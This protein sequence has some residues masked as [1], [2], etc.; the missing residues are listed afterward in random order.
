MEGPI[1]GVP[2]IFLLDT[3]RSM[4]GEGFAQ[5]KEAFLS[6]IQG[7]ANQSNVDH[8]VAVI[9]FGKETKILQL[10]SNDFKS[11][12]HLLDDIVCEGPSQLRK[13]MELAIEVL[14]TV[15]NQSSIGPFCI[16]EK[17]VIISRGRVADK[18][19]VMYMED[20]RHEKLKIVHLAGQIGTRHPIVCIPVGT[21]PDMCFLGSLACSS[22]TG[23][24]LS[25]EG[26]VQFT[27]YSSNMGIASEVIGNIPTT[28]YSVDDVKAAVQALEGSR[29]ITE[30]DVD[31]IYEILTH[32]H[33]YQINSYSRDTIETDLHSEGNPKLP[34]IGT[35]VRR[36]PNWPYNGQDSNTC[37][38]VV[39]HNHRDLNLSIEW[40]TSMIFPYHF[41]T[42]GDLG[43]S[44]VVV[45][46]EPRILLQREKIAVGCLV[47]RGPDWKWFDQDG[48]EDNVGSVYRVKD[49]KTVHVRWP[50]GNKS[51]YRFG[52][53]GKY[54]VSI[55]DPFDE[56]IRR[57]IEEQQK[58]WHK[59]INDSKKVVSNDGI[60]ISFS[61]EGR[62]ST[63]TI[64][65]GIGRGMVETGDSVIKA[66]ENVLEMNDS[67]DEARRESRAIEYKDEASGGG[68]DTDLNNEDNNSLWQW[69]NE[70][71]NW[72]YYPKSENDKIQKAHE[73]NSRGTILVRVNGDLY[74]VVLSKMIQ[75]NISSRESQEIRRLS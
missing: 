34:P 25:P 41:D 4:R 36:A 43:R 32:R 52:Y 63:L 48:G 53:D 44:N 60:G 57:R 14:F 54:D 27:K 66:S 75:I 46:D 37:G 47:Q 70:Q 74:R 38:T 8:S 1:K 16:R 15:L 42:D 61:K 65:I 62:N 19:D 67:S 7:Y 58:S 56:V 23:K 9:G 59:M 5:M 39:G 50:N 6:M 10:Y 21:N 2:I 72:V 55:C 22:K 24:L 30:K 29:N 26:V 49:D 73:K 20:N 17:V 40:D 45:C 13:A 28:G 31:D 68:E 11:I 64:T 51:N 3:S 18:N 69:K 71:G 35:R 12:L 33:M